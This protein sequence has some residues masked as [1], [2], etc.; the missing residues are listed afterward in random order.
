MKGG[1]RKRHVIA[2]VSSKKLVRRTKGIGTL[3]NILEKYSERIYMCTTI[4]K[5]LNWENVI[6]NV[7]ILAQRK[8]KD[9]CTSSRKGTIQEL[10]HGLFSKQISSIS[11]ENLFWKQAMRQ[12]PNG[13]VSKWRS[14]YKNSSLSVF[15]TFP[16]RGF[17]N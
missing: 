9:L 12:F 4:R 8:T 10:A 7:L 13:P 3:K 16:F 1:L 6:W 17:R 5:P 15:L 14:R 11:M 2:P